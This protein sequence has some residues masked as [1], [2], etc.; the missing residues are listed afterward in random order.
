MPAFKLIHK[1]ELEQ[2]SA[3]LKGHEWRNEDFTI[4][5]EAYDP[6]KAEVESEPGELIIACT[7]THRVRVYHLGRGSSWVTDF[8][9]DLAAGKFG[10]AP[11]VDGSPG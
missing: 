2:F 3:A 6:A 9:D 8:V 1:E 5:E 11:K 7:R 10:W 4:E